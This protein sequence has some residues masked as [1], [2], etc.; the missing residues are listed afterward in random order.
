M[1]PSQP[2]RKAMVRRSEKTQSKK[3]T[4]RGEMAAKECEEATHRP[5]PQ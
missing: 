4:K 3:R 1:S 5:L 2:E